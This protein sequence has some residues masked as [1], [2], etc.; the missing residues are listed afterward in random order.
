MS[1]GN[2]WSGGIPIYNNILKIKTKE[3]GNLALEAQ[4]QCG[5]SGFSATD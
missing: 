2:N 4:I 3:D 1:G 5:N